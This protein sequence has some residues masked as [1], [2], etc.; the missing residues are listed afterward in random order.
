MTDKE[1]LG[2]EQSRRRP[3]IDLSRNDVPVEKPSTAS[4]TVISLPPQ[5][6]L[7]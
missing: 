3:I 7:R 1:Q 4:S 2:R 5:C 6:E